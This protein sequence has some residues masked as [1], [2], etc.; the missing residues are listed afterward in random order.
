MSVPTL[1]IEPLP[2]VVFH[3][4]DEHQLTRLEQLLCQQVALGCVKAR[5]ALPAKQTYFE[6]GDR[7]IQKPSREPGASAG[8]R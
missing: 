1:S 5:G 8:S 6:M 3:W 2:L 4:P 7:E